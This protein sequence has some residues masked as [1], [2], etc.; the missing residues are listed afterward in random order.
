MK[1]GQAPSVLLKMG[2]RAQYKKLNPTPFV[3][4]KASPGVQNMKLDPILSI[5]LKT[6]LGALFTAENGSE[7]ANRE[8]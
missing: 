1:T 4:S 5:P 7:S 8:N 3:P 2:P 6:S